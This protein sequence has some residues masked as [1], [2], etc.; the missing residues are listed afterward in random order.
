MHP[1]LQPKNCINCQSLVQVENIVE[2][3][4]S[5]CEFG[6]NQCCYCKFGTSDLETYRIH[7]ANCHS[8]KMPL[9]FDRCSE[10]TQE[11]LTVRK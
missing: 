8:S 9:Y 3:L 1:E 5:C 4:Q 10:G 2:H 6:V 11:A 7:L